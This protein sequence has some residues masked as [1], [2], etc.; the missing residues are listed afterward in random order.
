MAHGLI[1]IDWSAPWFQPWRAD[2]ESVSARI[3]EGECLHDALNEG[4]RAPVRFVPHEAMPAGESYERFIAQSRQCP[5]RDGPHDFFNGLVWRAFPK[6]KAALNRLQAEAIERDGVGARRGPVRDAV[7]VFDENGALLD[8]PPA[9]WD[10]L[11]ARDWKR[12]FIDLRPLWSETRLTLFGHALMEQLIS[13][14]KGLTAHVF[15]ERPAAFS[16]ARDDWLCGQ[17]EAETLA[18]KPFTPLPVLGVPGWWAGSEDFCFY[19]DPQ[20]FRPRRA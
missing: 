15:T 7:T 16:S 17:I 2:G 14:R 1:G 12:L 3:A 20:V 5:V 18:V 8:A 13:P 9:L 4:W 11:L 6:A 10:A 19:D